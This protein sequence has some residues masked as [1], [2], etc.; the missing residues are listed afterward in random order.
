MSLSSVQ[1]YFINE[2]ADLNISI[3][4]LEKE[5]EERK[6]HIEELKLFIS[7]IEKEIKNDTLLSPIYVEKNIQDKLHIEEDKIEEDTLVIAKIAEEIKTLSSKKKILEKQLDTVS[8][9]LD[10]DKCFVSKEKINDAISNNEKTK[11]SIQSK[12]KTIKK[13]VDSYIK[14]DFKRVMLDFDKFEKDVE[15]ICNGIDD[16]NKNLKKI[17]K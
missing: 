15:D 6:L 9:Y 10:D 13:S 11:W 3:R 5:M 1:D 8:S 12:L 14:V 17:I 7:E 2:I 16:N 4:N